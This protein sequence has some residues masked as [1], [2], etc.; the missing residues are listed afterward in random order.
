MP[1]ANLLDG[2]AI[3][4]QPIEDVVRG[5]D[6]SGVPRERVEERLDMIPERAARKGREPAVMVVTVEPLRRS[7]V[8]NPVFYDRGDAVCAKSA[9]STLDALDIRAHQAAHSRGILT[10][11]AVDSRPARG[12]CKIRLRREGHVQ[13]RCAVLLANDVSETSYEPRVAD[14]RQPQ[15][16]G[17]LAETRR[18]Y[19][20]SQCCAHVMRRVG[21]DRLGCQS[22]SSRA[23][24]GWRCSVR[25]IA[26]GSS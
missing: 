7:A 19:S 18:V 12:G 10:K 21:A 8:A 17:P 14:R 13:T 4:H 6:T 24:A 15:C 11:G 5:H 23:T 20:S 26:G 3:E 1:H 9:P 2:H 22:G 25:Q 16:P